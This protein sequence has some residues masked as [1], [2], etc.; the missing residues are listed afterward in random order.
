MKSIKGKKILVTGAGGFIGSHLTET[1]LRQRAKVTALLRY[2]SQGRTGWLEQLPERLKTK[3]NIVFGDI[4]D[5]DICQRAVNGNTHVFHLAAQIAIPYS[6][7]APRDFTA[8]NV[9]GTANLL[10][11]ARE[12]GVKKFLQVSTSEVYGTARYVPIDENHPQT[13]QSPYS[14]S[15]IAADKLAQSFHLSFGLPTVTVRPFNCYGP[16]QSARAIIPTII[17]QALRGRTVRL[18]NTDSRRD[19]NYVSDIT[20]GMIAAAFTDK[21]TGVVLNLATGT[22]YSIGEIVDLVGN[23]LNKR[24]IIKSERKRIR[25]KNSEVWRLQGD[26]R[27]AA[28]LIGY[29]PKFALLLGMKKTIEFFENH[30]AMYD[31][32]DYQL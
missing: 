2:T 19:M 7:I 22:D 16:R 13:A 27:L 24:L 28:R 31:R 21:T 9:M 17:L 23:I 11:A 30:L 26:N 14:A 25:P 3:I 8:V 5:P 18:G 32:E 4:R 12:S 20:D 10:Q 1:L 6:Y 15:K 29:K